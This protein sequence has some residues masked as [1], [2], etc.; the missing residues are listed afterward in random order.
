MGTI[1]SSD[2]IFATLTQRG[3][4]VATFRF[5]GLT[6]IADIIKQ[7][8]TNVRNCIGMVTLQLRNGTQGWSQSRSLL[9]S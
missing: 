6:S 3:N 5:S 2:I 1:N 7:I 8:R 4:Q 9:L